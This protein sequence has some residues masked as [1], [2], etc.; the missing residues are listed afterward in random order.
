[1]LVSEI[2]TR[3]KYAINQEDTDRFSN[4]ELLDVINE[5]YVDFCRFTEMLEK[6]S[7]TVMSALSS[8]V[9][10][11][12]DFLDARQFRWSYNQVLY[13]YSARKLDYNE[14]R[15]TTQVGTNPEAV[16][17]RNWGSLRLKPI[18][19]TAGTLLMKYAYVPSTSLTTSDTPAILQVFHEA[20]VD[21]GAAECFYSM[22]DFKNGD[23]KWSLYLERR[24]KGKVQARQWQRTPDT[25]LS[26]RP[27]T[28]FNYPY[29]DNR[30]RSHS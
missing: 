10:L 24:E 9:S 29:W 27:V 18:I 7:T 3:I 1:M 28:V 16:V 14:A 17:Y 12:T 8:V 25:M 30:F 21:F 26:T 11:P 22:R 6:S 4:Q 20:L 2:I 5:G 19:S 23:L 15:W 13:P